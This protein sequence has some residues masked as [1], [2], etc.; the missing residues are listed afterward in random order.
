MEHS[1]FGVVKIVR[2][3]GKERNLFGSGA[4]HSTTVVLTISKADYSRDLHSDR[5]F[6][7]KDLIE[8]EL[9]EAQF[10]QFI[11][12]SGIG[13]GTP[14]TLRYIQG[15]KMEECPAINTRE[16]FSLEISESLRELQEKTK[17]LEAIA[18][19]LT[20]K[21]KLTKAD[22][23]RLTKAVSQV[24]TTVRSDIPFIQE[25]FE[26]V[27]DRSVNAA[28]IEADAYWLSLQTQ[29]RKQLTRSEND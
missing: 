28:K 17:K 12:S 9:S 19:E 16:Q 11:M 27:M 13:D 7:T 25:R 3:K 2:R 24:K 4:L 6:S 8:I 20:S 22:K 23:D 21:Q 18:S 10:A 5:I 1:S 15:E 29:Q 14:C 26:E